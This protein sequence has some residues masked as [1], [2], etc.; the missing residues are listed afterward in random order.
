MSVNVRRLQRKTKKKKKREGEREGTQLLL[1]GKAKKAAEDLT[2]R[3]RSQQQ[4][5]NKAL[6]N[7]IHA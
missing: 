5:Q 6:Q 2:A 7:K 4:K 3:F 1:N